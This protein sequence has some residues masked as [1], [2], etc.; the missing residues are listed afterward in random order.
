MPR[1]TAFMALLS[2]VF[3]CG[4]SSP[5]ER[6]PA[7]ATVPAQKVQLRFPSIPEFTT[8]LAKPPS[9]TVAASEAE[10]AALT[11]R[12]S[13]IGLLTQIEEGAEPAP[14]EGQGSA[15]LQG[16]IE[17]MA[18]M[19]LT[20]EQRKRREEALRR[21]RRPKLLE[22]S[23]PDLRGLM[24]ASK[25]E[26]TL[27]ILYTIGPDGA[28]RFPAI[29]GGFDAATTGAIERT[30]K[31]WRWQPALLDSNA[32]T[33]RAQTWLTLPLTTADWVF[34]PAQAMPP[35]ASGA[36]RLPDSWLPTPPPKGPSRRP[37]L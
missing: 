25:P 13:M 2:A 16:M 22:A 11:R 24:P 29:G 35:S 3:C 34:K 28:C 36:T 20:P 6:K 14:A 31:Q 7:D 8:T 17:G 21:T 12:T 26:V 37:R 5:Q 10:R 33:V 9:T 23:V 30:V 27:S 19:N 32:V 4:C 15:F 1:R 18:Y